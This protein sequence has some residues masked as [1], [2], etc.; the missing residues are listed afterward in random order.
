VKIRYQSILIISFFGIILSMIWFA[1]HGLQPSPESKIPP[2][3]M[4]EPKRATQISEPA[5]TPGTQISLPP[6]EPVKQTIQ[7]HFE[8]DYIWR[9]EPDI[10]EAPYAHA[11][12]RIEAER[13]PQRQE[14]HIQALVQ[15][16]IQ[17]GPLSTLNQLDNQEST[18]RILDLKIRILRKWTDLQ[19]VAAANWAA[20]RVNDAERGQALEAVSLVWANHPDDA[21]L[22]WADNLENPHDRHT[23]LT[24]IAFERVRSHP[25]QALE[26]AAE[27]D[28]DN[29]RDDLI[30]VAVSE[31]AYH[32]PEGAMDW[33]LNIED[34]E[35]YEKVISRVAQVWGSRM[36]VLGG[37]LAATA[38]SPGRSQNR[39]SAAIAQRWGQS[40]PVEALDWV[41]MFPSVKD[42]DDTRHVILEHWFGRDPLRAQKWVMNSG[43]SIEQKKFWLTNFKTD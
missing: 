16:L 31:W 21:V 22:A 41:E 14:E 43:F 19:P 35:L 18:P 42:R 11:L 30:Q 2:V 1:I 34:P 33:G 23:V 26:L 28:A 25:L 38:L 12:N 24:A 3:S 32:D 15:E 13:D 20:A 4:T 29:P 8:S 9:N 40:S 39:A 10:P 17:E 5:L 37:T 27:M 7:K 6:F 36:P